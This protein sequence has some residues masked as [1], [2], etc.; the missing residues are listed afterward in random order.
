MSRA[1]PVVLVATR[2][3]VE[4]RV[5]LEALGRRCLST[6]HVDDRSLVY[7]IGDPPPPW[8]A[9]LNRAL[10]ATRRVEISR[11][12]EVMGIP[13]LNSA[14]TLATCDNKIA[15]T[16]ALRCAGLPVPDTVVALDAA[17][18]VRA[19]DEVGFPAVVKPVVGSWGRGLAKVN[20]TDAAEAVF[21]LRA[22]SPSPVQK[23]AYA[24]R[25]VEGRDIRVLVVGGHAVAAAQRTSDHWVRNTARGARACPVPLDPG[26]VD[27]A[28]RA[29]KAV[30][31]G[32]LGVDVL[33]SCTGDRV[34]LEVNAG[35]EFHG[36]ASA[37]PDLPIADL[38]VDHLL[39]VLR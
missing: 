21:D 12:C 15:G 18:G 29:S 9:V 34:V 33:E 16:W 22:G 1:E 14:D 28:E 7:R 2:I 10:S 8:R 36:L 31:G 24:Q 27:L 35:V 3:R 39:E 30:G 26:L 37:H 17:A 32:I 23:L 5:L 25:F 20:D 6:V 11:Y 13:V 4:E 38:V 19:V